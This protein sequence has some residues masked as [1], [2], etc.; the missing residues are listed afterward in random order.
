MQPASGRGVAVASFGARLKREREQRGISLDDVALSTKIGARFLRAMEEEKFD[1]LPGGI[2][3]RGFVRAYAR[4]VGIDEEQ[5]VADY[6]EA[7]GETIPTGQSEPSIPVPPPV[8][9]ENKTK[10]SKE[11][12]HKE[13]KPNR[14]NHS[15]AEGIPWG[16]PV[17]CA[18]ES[19]RLCSGFEN[20]AAPFIPQ[21]RNCGTAVRFCCDP[22]G[23]ARTRHLQR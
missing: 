13:S 9:P 7:T 18:P 22:T 6:L 14:D 17:C 11:S 1:Q 23:P 16:E 20:W 10:D 12:A 15:T 2:F 4:R 21:P 5:A 19:C 3:N 8:P